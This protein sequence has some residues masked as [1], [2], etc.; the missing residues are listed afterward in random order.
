M[1]ADNSASRS[2]QPIVATTELVQFPSTGATS[3]A[4][5]TSSTSVDSTNMSGLQTNVGSIALPTQNRNGVCGMAR[6]KIVTLVVGL[7]A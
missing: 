3:T 2:V 4:T 7:V 1:H 5:G 6:P